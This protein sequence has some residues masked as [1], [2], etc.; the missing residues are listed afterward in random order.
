M[1]REAMKD[2]RKHSDKVEKYSSEQQTCVIVS[3]TF[4][5]RVYNLSSYNIHIIS[6]Q[7]GR[8]D[9]ELQNFKGFQEFCEIM[10]TA[11]F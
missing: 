10:C 8:Q 7:T 1:K 4:I 2:R 9:E 3:I 11:L 5:V 6:R